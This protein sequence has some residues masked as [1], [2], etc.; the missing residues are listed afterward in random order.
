MV[1][2]IET[3]ISLQNIFCRYEGSKIVVGQKENRWRYDILEGPLCKKCSNP[4]DDTA[5][6]GEIC[7]FCFFSSDQ[8]YFE[9]AYALGSYHRYKSTLT[10][11]NLSDH[12]LQLKEQKIYSLPLGMALFLFV[13]QKHPK[14]L[15]S[16]VVIPIPMHPLKLK[17]HNF[18]HSEELAKIFCHFSKIPINTTSLIKKTNESM[19]G[20]KFK[21]RKKIAKGMY[22]CNTSVEGNV[23]LIDDIMTSTATAMACAEEL[24]SNGAKSVNVLVCARNIYEPKEE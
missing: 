19:V 8:L 22:K 10:T 12:A 7:S 11:D 9:K 4:I 15:D 5:T 16:N 20:R 3:Q 17:E 13:N 1:E 24:I 2:K 23:L 18:N 6:Y 21:E 14:L